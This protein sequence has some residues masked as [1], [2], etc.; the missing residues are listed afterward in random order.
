MNQPRAK[1]ILVVDDDSGHRDLYA[2]ILRENGY[3]V[4]EAA[5]GGRALAAVHKQRP[6]LVF[7]DVRMP[8]PSGLEVLESIRGCCPD[9]PFLLVTAYPDV[10]E[11]VAAL[12]L[13]AVD[14]LAKPV[15]LDELLAVCRE[16]LGDRDESGQDDLPAGALEGIV[17]ESPALRSVLRDA[18]QVARSDATVLLTG[19]SGA[20]KEVLAQFIHRH[21]GRADGPLIAVNCAALPDGLVAS[22]LFGH[23]PGSF[24][25][26]TGR[27][28]GRFREADGG[29]LFLDEIGDMPTELQPALL[30]VLETGALMP[31]GGTGEIRVDVRL[32][33][34]TNVALEKAVEAG[35]FREDLYHR[36]NVIAL[37]LPPLRQR[38]ED[39]L[40]LARSFLHNRGGGKR[41][42]PAAARTLQNYPWPGNVRELA[43]AMERARLLSRTEVILPEHLPPAV[44]QGAAAGAV[45]PGDVSAQ[46]STSPANDEPP[47]PLD[48]VERETIEK[49]LERTG[50][51][52]TRAAELLGISRRTLI[53]KL[54]RYSQD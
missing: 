14:Y 51:N 42:S 26:V 6:D 29:T 8:G 21:S 52:R 18:W 2:G 22:E 30:R 1:R 46:P 33:A 19:E 47:L 31:V 45:S 32:I 39:V 12:K 43:N 28:A 27:R 37:P 23:E 3:D 41:L 4:E 40:P 44:R 13:G 7:S 15:D 16:I 53:Y 34:A 50:G 9:L 24:T 48:R 17:A 35:R 11:A 49:A 20:G 54:K 5:D 36:L 25:G 10:R 38:P